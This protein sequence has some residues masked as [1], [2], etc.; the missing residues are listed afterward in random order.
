MNLCTGSARK[1]QRHQAE[2]GRERGHE[3]GAEAD[4]ASVNDRIADTLSFAAQVVKVGQQHHGVLHR[5]PEQGDEA[6]GGR[7]GEILPGNPKANHPADECER[8]VEDNH[9]RMP[10]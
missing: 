9:R 10:Q 3:D 1:E 2:Q 4:K 6:D 5:D 7:N 8:Y